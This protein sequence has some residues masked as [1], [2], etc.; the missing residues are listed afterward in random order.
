[1]NRALEEILYERHPEIFAERDLPR[2][3]SGMYWGVQWGDAWF[4]LRWRKLARLPF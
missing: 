3:F 1:M 4:P 2:E